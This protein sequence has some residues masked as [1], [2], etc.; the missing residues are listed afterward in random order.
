MIIPTHVTLFQTYRKF[1][2]ESLKTDR[3][4]LHCELLQTHVTKGNL[5]QGLSLNLLQEQCQLGAVSSRLQKMNHDLCCWWPFSGCEIVPYSESVSYLDGLSKGDTLKKIL[6]TRNA[7]NFVTAFE[8]RQQSS[9]Q[10]TQ[11]IFSNK[12]VPIDV[13]ASHGLYI[14]VSSRL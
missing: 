9:L 1:K 2:I 5:R 14:P 6:N 3:K 4:K 13:H 11:P 7:V 10:N 12:D 8:S